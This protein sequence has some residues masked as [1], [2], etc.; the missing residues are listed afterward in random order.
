MN[1]NKPTDAVAPQSALRTTGAPARR[2]EAGGSGGGK[3]E[4]VQSPDSVQL[5]DT[6]R[7]LSAAGQAID[8]FRED[9][10]AA[11]KRALEM[12]T[13]QVHARIVADRMISE[14]SDVLRL[15]ATR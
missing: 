11:V 2:L 8:Q 12:G 5:S 9:K 14:A 13:Y 7:A 4:G 1:I 3:V 15:M 10:V 6:G